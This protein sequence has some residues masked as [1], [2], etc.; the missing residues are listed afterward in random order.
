MRRWIKIVAA[1]ALQ[2]VSAVALAH[3]GG[4]AALHEGNIWSQWNFQPSVVVPLI[5]GASLYLLGLW[6]LWGRAGVGRGI[7]SARAMS[8]GLGIAAL[9]IAL[10]SPLDSIAG[11]LF[12]VHM[13]QHLL[14]IL[15]APPLLI[16]GNPDLAL[17]WALPQSWR[18]RWGRG[19]QRLG[20]TISSGKGPL[21]IIAV[22][23]GVLWMWHLPQLYDLAVRNEAVH[24]AEHVG[25]LVTGVLFWATVLR[26]RRQDHG[27]N[28]A[29]ILYVGAM[30]LQGSL[31]GALITFA[32]QPLYRSH[33]PTTQQWG[34]TPL[35]DQQLAG[36]IMWVPPALL[37]LG[38]VAYLFVNWLAAVEARNKAGGALRKQASTSGSATP[39]Y[40]DVR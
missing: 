11:A 20:R 24:W 13:V 1:A 3:G 10:M 2:S 23:T 26:L 33:L 31:L 40:V 14:L 38:V 25:F 21:V 28:G 36:L 17:L 29:R 6:R 19:E 15:V 5:V 7:S 32:S 16:V 30:A 37:Y 35:V 9:V 34:F 18:K 8:Y 27:G 4:A 12:W 39:R 22:S